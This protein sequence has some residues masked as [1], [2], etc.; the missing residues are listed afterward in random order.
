MKPS[1]KR[2]AAD[3]L[4]ATH[5]LSKV[6]ACAAVR[7][8]RAAF[9]RRPTRPADDG[10]VIEALNAV[11]DRYP[12]W[13]FWKCFDRLRLDGQGWNHKRVWRVYREMRLNLP[14]RTKKR[15]PTRQRQTLEVPAAPNAIWAVDFMSDALY[16]GRR[17]RTLNI[18]DEGVR[19]ALDIVIDTSIPSGRVVRTLE[20]LCSWRGPPQAIRCDNGPEFVSEVFAD[21]CKEQGIE[22]RYIQPGKP[23]Q[24]AY[25]E[26]FNRTYRE[27]VL[28]AYL[29][30]DLAQVREITYRWLGDYN[31]TRPHDSLGRIPP[32]QFR[33][34]LSKLENSTFGWST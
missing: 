30:E 17:F 14:R 26:R 11:V 9:Y 25:V 21:W 18:L 3:F 20:Q 16:Q 4:V 31:D 5:R 1:E 12:R 7:L 8:S 27:E 32:S 13:G 34:N 33:R 24:N 2:E 10:P 29:F 22:I 6:R 15:I 23:N 19:E 28:N